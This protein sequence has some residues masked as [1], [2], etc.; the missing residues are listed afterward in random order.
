MDNFLVKYVY[1][2]DQNYFNNIIK[3][4]NNQFVWKRTTKTIQVIIYKDY[5]N[6]KVVIT[7]TNA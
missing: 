1:K 3:V 6:N 4:H 2:M 5:L 7:Q